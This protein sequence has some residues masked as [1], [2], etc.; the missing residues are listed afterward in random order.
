LIILKIIVTKHITYSRSNE[1]DFE[2]LQA[3]TAMSKTL[4]IA[5]TKG[6]NYYNEDTKHKY[7]YKRNKKDFKMKDRDSKDQ[8][9]LR[10]E[11][12]DFGTLKIS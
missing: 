7:I 2:T 3:I 12:E 9:L 4:K 6:R 8:K 5:Q 10:N 11:I 1:K